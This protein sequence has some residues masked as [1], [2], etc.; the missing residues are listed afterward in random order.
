MTK[1]L[2]FVSIGLIIV[3]ACLWWCI[4]GK[5]VRPTR[6]T[7]AESVGQLVAKPPSKGERLAAMLDTYNNQDIVFYG[8][9][10]DRDGNPLTGVSVKAEVLYHS[11]TAEG[12]AN[13][14]AASDSRGYFVINGIKGEGVSIYLNLPGYENENY[15][16]IFWYTELL[17]A[18]KRHQPDAEHPVTFVMVK[19]AGSAE[20]AH[21]RRKGFR[22]PNDGTPVRINLADGKIVHVGGDLEISLLH[23][24]SPAGGRLSHFTWKL[25]LSSPGGGLRESNE[26]L[27]YLAP[28]DGYQP[29]V[30]TGSEVN[31]NFEGE[32]KKK[33]YVRT[34]SGRFARIVIDLNIDTSPEVA[35]YVGV[36][37]WLNAVA[38]DRNLESD[39]SR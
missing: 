20:V 11:S 8:K 27:M 13:V 26:G 30:L 36:A 33:F 22:V 7:P 17:E 21:F 3:G 28:Q 5:Q 19:L 9:V 16:N 1:R 15:R 34:A 31:A 24:E 23:P 18:S 14:V 35:S 4:N 25:E 12:V 6:A 39:G 37:S 32:T 38:G 29:V 2:A 10:I